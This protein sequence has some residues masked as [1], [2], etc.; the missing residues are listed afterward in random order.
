MFPKFN[1]FISK[2]SQ[3]AV[4]YFFAADETTYERLKKERMEIDKKFKKMNKKCHQF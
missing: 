2:S 4:S 3:I 1:D